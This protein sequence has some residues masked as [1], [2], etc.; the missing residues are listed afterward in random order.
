MYFLLIFGGDTENAFGTAWFIVFYIVC[1]ILGGL[2]HAYVTYFL[3]PASA[4]VPTIGASGAIFGVLASY[5]LFFPNRPLYTFFGVW[6]AIYFVFFV[7]AVETIMAIYPLAGYGI[8][9]TAHI[10]GFIAGALFTLAFKAI[11]RGPFKK[12]KKIVVYYF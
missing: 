1:G 3:F 12:K 2:F 5:A 11:K 8:A 6:K 7:V 4:N 10:G 9:H